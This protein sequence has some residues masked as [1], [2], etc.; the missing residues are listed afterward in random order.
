LKLERGRGDLPHFMA[1]LAGPQPVHAEEGWGA[2]ADPG[3]GVTI[4]HIEG[5]R[6]AG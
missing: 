5:W 3:L 1:G 6:F 2:E 4:P